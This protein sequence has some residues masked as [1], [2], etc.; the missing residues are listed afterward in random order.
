MAV[1][2]WKNDGQVLYGTNDPTQGVG[3][4]YFQ[5]IQIVVLILLFGSLK[6][7]RSLTYM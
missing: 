1:F 5:Q 2:S 4:L 7:R 6:S 3:V